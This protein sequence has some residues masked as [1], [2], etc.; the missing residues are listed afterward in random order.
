ML[1]FTV[2]YTDIAEGRTYLCM[3]IIMLNY[4]I[5]QEYFHIYCLKFVIFSV[6]SKADF[7]MHL[8][9]NRLQES[10]CGVSFRYQMCILWKLASVVQIKECYQINIFNLSI[11]AW[12]D[13]NW[14]R[15]YYC[16]LKSILEVLTLKQTKIVMEID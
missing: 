8:Q 7:P 9:K 6:L 14:L 1:Y 12:L 10:Q 2:I 13:K 4:P 15:L 3:E 11:S 5:R 16:I